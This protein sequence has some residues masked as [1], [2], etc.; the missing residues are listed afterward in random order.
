MALKITL[1]FALIATA[2]E[3]VY[4][5]PIS[6]D[7]TD[8]LNTDSRGSGGANP[9]GLLNGFRSLLDDPLCGVGLG[10]D[11]CV[12]PLSGL[13]PPLGGPINSLGLG[14]DCQGNNCGGNDGDVPIGN[15]NDDGDVP[16][17]NCNDDENVPIG[18]GNGDG[19]VP[20]G[21]GNDDGDCN[22]QGDAVPINDG[23]DGHDCHD[24][25]E[26]E[27]GL[28]VHVGGGECDE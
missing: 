25:D 16:I 3:F 28:D 21:D 26:D 4:S 11:D 13:Q 7:L 19:N 9:N 10:C 14:V 6:G 2:I 24:C 20:I 8:V 22:C 18:G 17:G 15:G 5:V 1:L 23:D 27:L 12:G